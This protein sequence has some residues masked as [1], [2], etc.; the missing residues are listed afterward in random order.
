[1]N[2]KP[3]ILAIWMLENLTLGKCNEALAGDLLEEFRCGRSALW[4]WRQVLATMIIGSFREIISRRTVLIFAV[5]WSM[6]S[7]AWVLI[8]ANLEKHF[9]FND[10]VL[11]MEWP[12]NAFCDIGLLLAANL[13]FIWV[14][15]LL[16]LIAHSWIAGNFKPRVLSRGIVA[17]VPIIIAIWVALLIFP[18]RFLQSQRVVQPAVISLHSYALTGMAP[19]RFAQIPAE[20]HTPYNNPRHAISNTGSAALLVRLPFFLCVLYALWGASHWK[21]EHKRSVNC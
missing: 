9:N 1:M 3:P 17:S 18:Q 13:I 5:F 2:A 8:V 16:Y 4:Y 11:Q 20:M 6:L 7:P 21:S 12:W 19:P 15:I 14:G 10:R